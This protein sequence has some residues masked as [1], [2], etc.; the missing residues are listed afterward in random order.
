MHSWPVSREGEM[1]DKGQAELAVE[2]MRLT[3]VP[4]NTQR[5]EP[6]SGQWARNVTAVRSNNL[7]FDS[8]LI[9]ANANPII[10]IAD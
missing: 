2:T 7:D 9:L 8:T 4:Q 5:E 1:A 10:G 6:D 3:A